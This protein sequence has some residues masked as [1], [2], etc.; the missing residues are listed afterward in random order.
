MNG[1]LEQGMLQVGC[2]LLFRQAEAL[3]FIH[4]NKN[5][6]EKSEFIGEHNSRLDV[7][8]SKRRNQANGYPGTE[9]R[10]V[11]VLS[12]EYLCSLNYIL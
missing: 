5:S 12:Q 2:S 11:T 7:G 3:W 8:L 9:L 6:R 10:G 4:R 1:E